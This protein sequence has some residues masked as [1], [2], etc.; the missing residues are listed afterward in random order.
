MEEYIVE[1]PFT[2]FIEIKIEAENEEEA[3]KVGFEKICNIKII[4]TDEEIYEKS[5]NG[6]ISYNME[7]K[8][9]IKKFNRINKI[10]TYCRWC[11][12]KVD[13][14]AE[15][16]FCRAK[17][18]DTNDTYEYCNNKNYYHDCSDFKLL[19]RLNGRMDV[20]ILNK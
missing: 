8:V 6:A 5:F 14:I 10:P 4:G 11:Q 13:T 7:R 12:H 17:I 16:S 2:G 20:M 9:L 19:E 15:R 18:D 3:Q 1:V